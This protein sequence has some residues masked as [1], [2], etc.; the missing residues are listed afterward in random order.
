MDSGQAEAF[1]FISGEKQ[2][3]RRP[4]VAL[5]VF[6]V[7]RNPRAELRT[8]QARWRASQQVGVSVS[9]RLISLLGVRLRLLSKHSAGHCGWRRVRLGKQNLTCFNRPA[10]SF[11]TS[12]LLL[13]SFFQICASELHKHSQPVSVSTSCSGGMFPIQSLV[14]LLHDKSAGPAPWGAH[15]HTRSR[16]F[17]EGKL[18]LPR[19]WQ[20]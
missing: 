20:L 10:R 15:D 18:Q 8:L 5:C 3:L 1:V 16:H 19:N 6:L 17:H 14:L 7:T 9:C 2:C 12:S 4:P 13:L 11:G